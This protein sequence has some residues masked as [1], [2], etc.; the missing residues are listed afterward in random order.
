M[1]IAK[2]YCDLHNL[3]S[4][5]FLITICCHCSCSPNLVNHQVLVESM[6]CERSHIGLYASRDVSN[7]VL[8][9]DEITTLLV[10]LCF[11]DYLLPCICTTDCI[12]GRTHVWLSLW[13]STWGR[14]SLLLWIFELPGTPSLKTL[15]LF[16]ILVAKYGAK[17]IIC[18]MLYTIPLWRSFLLSLERFH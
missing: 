8:W 13:S 2:D 9:N 18:S 15:L 6:D 16:C 11:M 1:H 3:L 7:F 10:S 17:I 4:V 12:G 5:G 14:F